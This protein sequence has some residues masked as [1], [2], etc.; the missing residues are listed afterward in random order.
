MG[1]AV[2]DV[3]KLKA[4]PVGIADLKTRKSA[5]EVDVKKAEDQLVQARADLAAKPSVPADATAS[6]DAAVTQAEAV[7][8]QKQ[9]DLDSVGKQLA[10]GDSKT[11]GFLLDLLSDNTGVS[12]HRF[13]MVVWT[14]VLGAMFAI[15]VWQTYRMPQFD[16][17][18][19]A[20]MGISSGTYLGFK[21]PE[22]PA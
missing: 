2:I 5:L 16:P 4:D 1:A 14:I 19:L 18:L 15:G 12:L 11:Q 13:Q 6:P 10:A 20:L 3:N 22:K 8:K 17:S 9:A 21:I 7:L